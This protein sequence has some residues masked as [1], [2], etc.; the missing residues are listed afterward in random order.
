MIPRPLASVDRVDI[1]QLLLHGR[2]EDR[3]LEY[4]RVLPGS[5]DDD[6]REF[7]ADVASFANAV[8]GDILFGI[9]ESAG[10]PQ[11]IPGVKLD[12]FDSERLRL[13]SLIRDGIQP[14][15]PAVEFREIPGFDHGSVLILRIH[16]SWAAPHVV[17]FKNLSRFYIRSAGQRHQMDVVEL[18]AAFLGNEA[19]LIG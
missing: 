8:G 9:D 6:K 14:R 3:Q 7:L 1:D 17:S 12:D 10:V 16:Q 4:K 18:R 15:I 13:Q 5:S 2:V 19:W 11:S